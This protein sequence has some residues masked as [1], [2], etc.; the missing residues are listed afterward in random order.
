MYCMGIDHHAQYS[1]I[2][3]LDE[4]GREVKAGRVFNTR[5]E[6]KKFLEGLEDVEA[7]I[8]SG[9]SS[10]TMVDL[11]EELGVRVKIANP[12]QVKA[13][14][15]ARIKTDKRDSR[16]LA[17][18]LRAGLIPEV[19]RRG[20]E[21]RESQQVLRQRVFYVRMLARVKNRI[22]TLLAQQGEEV[23]ERRAQVKELSTRKG[24]EFLKGL[25]LGEP[26][27]KLL[28]CLLASYDHL[29]EKIKES[30][31]LVKGLYRQMKEVQRVSTVPGFGG[32]FSVLV[33]TEMADISRF[34][35]AGKLHAYAGV[36]PSTHSSGERSYHG[37]IVKAGNRWLRWAAVEA[38]TPACRGDFDIRLFYERFARRKGANVAKVA[39]ARRLLTIIYKILKEERVYAPYKHQTKKESA[40]F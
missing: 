35:D 34:E 27:Q 14:A 21:N 16:I 36:I 3:V 1:Q 37:K 4:D 12:S 10:Y 31:S 19:Y 7:V 39:T 32:F 38:V 28:S 8:E 33:A 22:W 6:V 13:I 26:D 9:R 15:K 11:M 30:D 23:R 29:E 25:R 20:K 17:H 2:T 18:L 40:A 5:S 24:K